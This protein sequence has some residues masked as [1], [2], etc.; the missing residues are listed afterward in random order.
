MN[1][2]A[3]ELSKVQGVDT[4]EYALGERLTAERLNE[5][6]IWVRDGAIAFRLAT[7]RATPGIVEIFGPGRLLSPK[8]WEGAPGPDNRHAAALFR[9]TTLELPQEAL[10]RQLAANP[11]LATT[12]VRAS[13]EQHRAA[14]D[15]LTMLALRDPFRRVA[16]ALLLLLERLPQSTESVERTRL[17]V[18]QELIAAFAGL[19]RQTTNRQ[20][21]RLARA[22]VVLLRRQVVELRDPTA[23]VSVA[24][25]RRPVS[26]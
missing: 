20:L 22:G 2:V 12:L 15:R 9:T 6:H 3:A 10:D 8:L 17:A 13:A 18:G 14:L 19:S 4:R 24:A 25:G 26:R 5:R 1:G 11:H 16:H 21:R 23:L 7:G